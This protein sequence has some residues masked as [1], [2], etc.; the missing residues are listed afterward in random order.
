[1]GEHGGGAQAVAAF[2]PWTRFQT[3]ARGIINGLPAIVA[4]GAILRGNR[5][6]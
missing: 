1:M 5:R 3:W 6:R 2:I 4:V